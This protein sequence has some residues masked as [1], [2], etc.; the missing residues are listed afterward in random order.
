MAKVLIPIPPQRG[1]INPIST[2]CGLVIGGPIR[3]LLV[4][5]APVFELELGLRTEPLFL[6]ALFA[7]TV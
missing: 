5:V 4:A 2:D 3:L 7:L 1:F 6:A